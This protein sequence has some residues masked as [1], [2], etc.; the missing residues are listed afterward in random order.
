MQILLNERVG[1]VPWEIRDAVELWAR[2]QGRHA[3]VEWHRGLGCAVIHFSRKSD[4]PM[5][6]EWQEGRLS[7]EPTESV[8][9]HHW[10]P[11]KKRHVPLDLGEY[12]ASGIVNMLDESNVWSGRGRYAS[13]QAAIEAT[14][15]GHNQHRERLRQAAE[16]AGRESAWLHQR[17]VLGLPQVPVV[18]DVQSTTP[19]PD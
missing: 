17:G 13:L 2:Q 9:L 19:E 10:D 15:T 4:D 11:A 6:R 12:G 7:E 14:I 16:D 8:M 1:H 3:R 5:M 18:A